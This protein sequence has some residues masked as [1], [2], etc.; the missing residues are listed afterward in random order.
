MKNTFAL[1]ILIIRVISPYGS[2]STRD[3]VNLT[4]DRVSSTQ[5]QVNS[6]NSGTMSANAQS[7]SA[8]EKPRIYLNTDYTP[9]TGRTIAVA[10]GG[11]FQGALNQAQ[12]GDVITLEAG[13]T[14]TGNFTLPNKSESG[15]SEWIVIRSSTT[16]SN[17][18]P[19]GT[20]I[21]PSYSNVLP[22]IASPNSEPAIRAVSGAHH[23]RFIGLEIGH[24]A[25]SMIYAIVDF[26]GGQTSLS[27]IPHD[28]IVD[29]CYIHG[30]PSDTSRRG[31]ALNSAST[32][33]IDSYISECHESGADSQAIAGW[34]G[35]GPFKIVNNYLEGAGEN[36]I[37]G[38]ADPSIKNLIPSDIEFRHN[39]VAKPLKWKMGH[40][41]Y[42]GIR[43]SVKNLFELKNAQRV[44]IE[45]NIFEYNWAESQNGFAI[46]FTPRNQSGRSPWSVAQDVK[47]AD[48]ALRR[49]GGGFNIAGPDNEAGV[50][51]PSPRI[52]IRNNRIEDID[53]KAWGGDGKLFQ[54]IGGAEYVTIDHNTGF[55]TGNILTTESA[56]GLNVALV[57]T[58][59]IVAHNAYG[60]IGTETGIGLS[61]LRRWWKSYVFKKN[62]VVVGQASKYLV[63]T[64]FINSFIEVGFVDM[65]KGDYRH[66]SSSSYRNVGADS[67]NIGCNL[68]KTFR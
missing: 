40:P 58:N 50:R 64:Y 12:P 62:V 32:A 55:A 11:D 57:F 3:R 46:L 7:G 68:N 17:L 65:A 49:S 24:K 15:Q 63:E 59:N 36:F 6:T 14:F 67:K 16:D 52:L 19:P 66:S 5:G 22:K 34:N 13:A 33:V 37:L 26:D 9:P 54:I 2:C 30:N 44:L 4:Q 42:A 8:P 53:G 25:G 38:G 39:H 45:S 31:V 56:Q 21:S 43:W 61:T 35:P 1:A 10:A 28:L 60:V 29:R 18:P 47:F 20:R 27:Q 23:F 48:N 51:Q 41:S